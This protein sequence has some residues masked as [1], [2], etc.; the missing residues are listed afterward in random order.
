MRVNYRE[1][2]TPLFRIL[3]EDQIEEILSG[4]LEI[5]E[6]VGVKIEDEEAVELLKKGGAYSP[7]GVLVRIPSFMVKRALMTAPSRIVLAGRDGK[8]SL[9]LEKD[10]IYFG[11][12][13]DVPFFMDPNTGKRR[14]TVFEDVI[15]A[16]RVADALSNIDFFMSLGLVSDVPPKNY[17]R[18]QFLA[19]MMGTT[20]PLVITS[21]DGQ[22]L[23]DQFEMASLVLGGREKFRQNPLF[24]I[25]AEPI[26]P[27]IHP[28]TTVEKVLVSAEERIPLVF[29]PAPSAGGTAPVTMAGILVE[30]IADTLAGLVISQLKNPGTGFLM[31]GVFTTLDL[32][33]AVFSYGAPELLLLDAALTD[34]SKKLGI[35][36]FST[37]GCSDA[38]ELDQQA[39][40]E[41][42]LSILM[43]AQSG[44]NLIH[45]VGYLE[46][47]LLGSLDML[48]LSDEAISLVKRIM[49]GI[50]V[51]K[52]TL[53]VD[54][55]S[56]VG[57][58]GHFLDNP[59]TLKNFKKEIWVPT[60]IDRNLFDAWKSAG[61]RNMGDRCREKVLHILKTH[62][63]EPM[64]GKKMLRELRAIIAKSDEKYA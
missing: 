24:G 56:N 54:V 2:I 62:Q 50:R 59:H 35:P 40:L 51:N 42:G 41:A 31:G 58:G 64:L 14:K 15:N 8:R 63:P 4:S 11:T 55:I 48:V 49:R 27:L 9:V 21:V 43:A 18:H 13:S 20:K 36:V 7:D 39:G 1:N 28:K 26:S 16:A 44:A 12:G 30:G 53:A 46:S 45:D 33:T 25:Y 19:M 6:H 34:I 57:P 38:K 47:G 5:L 29:V 32:R 37:A 52:E 60:L 23:K 61:S 22:G 10:R 3:S 17:D